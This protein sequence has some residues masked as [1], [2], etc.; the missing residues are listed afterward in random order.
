MWRGNE[1]LPRTTLSVPPVRPHQGKA[2]RPAGARQCGKAPADRALADDVQ[3]SGRP[4][5]RPSH[6]GVSGSIAPCHCQ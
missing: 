4:A 5:G 2:G 6:G 1:A 3:G